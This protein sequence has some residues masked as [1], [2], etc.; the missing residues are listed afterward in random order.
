MYL[1]WVLLTLECISAV[2][3][4]ANAQCVAS[5]KKHI[6]YGTV[7]LHMTHRVTYL[8]VALPLIISKVSLL[9]YIKLLTFESITTKNGVKVQW[10]ILLLSSC[11]SSS[12]TITILTPF[13][14]VCQLLS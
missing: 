1:R 10:F 11:V 6:L 9:Y 12:C 7:L 14:V 8:G 3:N 5:P 4:S 2:M 13:K